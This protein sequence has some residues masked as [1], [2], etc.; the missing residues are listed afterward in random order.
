MRARSFACGWTDQ[1]NH[2]A[3]FHLG[4]VLDLA[5]LCC[6][7][8]IC[9]TLQKF[10]A[11][12]LVRHLTAAKAQRDF[13][14]V[15]VVEKLD[16][17]AHFDVVIMR[18]GVRAELDIFDLDDLMLFAGLGF[19]LLLF[20]FELAEIHYFANGW[21]CIGRNLDKVEFC[22]FGHNHGLRRRHNTYVFAIGANQTDFSACDTV[23]DAGASV[24]LW[25]RVMRSTGYGFDPCV[26][27]LAS[28][29]AG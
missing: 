29:R 9:D 22:L 7:H 24:A 20:V 12:V 19:A 25:R 3:A 2:L 26:V 28:R 18:V 16:H 27:D 4:E 15:T 23:I 13:D 1:H 6:D 10:A 21:V 17:V 14:F 5:E 8:V 11:Q